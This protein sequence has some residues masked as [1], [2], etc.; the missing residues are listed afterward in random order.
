MRART[1]FRTQL[2]LACTGLTLVALG[3]A[4]PATAQRNERPASEL[5][6]EYPLGPAA[7][8]NAPRPQAEVQAAFRPPATDSRKPERQARPAEADSEEASTI[9]VGLLV[10]IG[11][12]LVAP[13]V[14]VVR[15]ARQPVPAFPDG[16]AGLARLGIAWA[17]R[18]PVVERQGVPPFGKRERKEAERRRPERQNAEKRER[19]RFGGLRRRRR[20]RPRRVG[21]AEGSGRPA[22]MSPVDLADEAVAGLFTR[23]GR[24]SLTVLGTVIGLAALV[25]TL[26]LSRTANNRIATHFDEVAA[27]EVHVTTRPAP[28]DAPPNRIPWGAPA[29][30][31]RLNG[32]VAAGNLSNVDVG[33]ALVSTSP[34]NDPQRR[35]DLKLAV[36]AASRELFRAVRADL[37]T[38]R[39]PDE[40]HSRR[41]ERVAVLGRQAADR[42]GIHG[43]EH[44]P[45]ISIGDEIFLVT[46]ILDTVARQHD[47]LAAVIIPEGTARRLYRLASPEFVVVETRL[48][49]TRLIAEQIPLALT[50]EKPE[51][52]KVTFA[53]EEKRV[54]EAVERDLT[55]LFLTL[56]G[57]SLVVG[58]IGIA[59]VTLVSVM[60]RTGEIGLRRAL[61]ATRRHIALQFL[62]ESSA[63][64]VV[65][66][67]LGASL[68][69]LVVVAVSAYQSW[70]PV[71]DPLAPLAAPLLG[72]L[73]GLIAGSYPSIRAARME[74][75]EA[76]RSAT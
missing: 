3:T 30:L 31:A 56:G 11:F 12:L 76:L 58:A 57:V 48:G 69:T 47:L 39:L 7:G 63:M 51:A 72:G 17:G 25:A 8:Q 13:A 75:V 26:G 19:E 50:P 10:A 66:G 62:L 28:Q 45:A 52:L 23:P 27:T 67:V 61:G 38:G 14:L 74:P 65:G 29:R 16:S 32:V 6:R 21:A 55:L 18:G 1:R 22:A 71:L 44:L 37:R 34:V 5:W 53:P 46:G 36:Q 42:L 9:V 49:A 59:N 73:I 35:T 33:D 43:L 4:A 24:T 70:T 60:E 64:G 68:G 20:S 40:G 15:R 2:V 54:R 41:G